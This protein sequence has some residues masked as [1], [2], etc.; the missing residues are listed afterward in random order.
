ML[1]VF[2]CRKAKDKLLNSQGKIVYEQHHSVY[3]QHHPGEQD[4]QSTKYCLMSLKRSCFS[5]AR[6][7]FSRLYSSK[8]CCSK[9]KN[10]KFNLGSRE[11]NHLHYVGLKVVWVEKSWFLYLFS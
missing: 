8:A 7:L 1:E 5:G 6:E 9:K 10:G 2:L 3:E 4:C 11:K